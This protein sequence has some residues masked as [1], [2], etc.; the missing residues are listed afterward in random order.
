[1]DPK[2]TTWAYVRAALL[3]VVVLVHGIRVAP[4]P[5]VVKPEELKDPVAKEE[6]RRWTER[7]A[8][9]GY[10]IGPEELGERVVSVTGVIGRAHR[11]LTKP[12]EPF[13]RW[14]GTNQGWALFANPDTHP[15]RLRV[16]GV[17]DGVR[18]VL[19]LADDDEHAW[20]EPVLTQRRIRPLHDA[21][22]ARRKPTGSYRRFANWVWVQAKA[23]Y[24]DLDGIE[25]VLIETH[26]ALPGQRHSPDRVRH[27]VKVPK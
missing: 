9:L 23:D 15:S 3:F 20:L 19:F 12:F 2:P 10:T 26:S 16:D 1:M 4:L 13:F 7:L 25:L 27:T 21:K 14:T 17:R 24:P 5:Q 18:E 6:V 11:S 8:A 22:G